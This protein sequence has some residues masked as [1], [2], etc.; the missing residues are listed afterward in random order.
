MVVIA[1]EWVARCAVLLCWWFQWV[2]CG[3]EGWWF[4]GGYRVEVMYKV[5]GRPIIGDWYAERSILQH[6]DATLPLQFNN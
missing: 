2:V 6:Q 4:D 3:G 5:I 1:V